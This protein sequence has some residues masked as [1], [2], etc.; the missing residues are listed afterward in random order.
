[1]F[2]LVCRQKYLK[3]PRW[4]P[5]KIVLN[6][7]KMLENINLNKLLNNFVEKHLVQN[8]GAIQDG[9]AH[10]IFLLRYLSFSFFYR[11]NWPNTF[12]KCPNTHYIVLIAC[13]RFFLNGA[14]I[15][16]GV[17]KIFEVIS[18]VLSGAKSWF[19]PF[20]YCF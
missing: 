5:P 3:W 14:I 11:P 12:C 9:L 17:L 13:K 7:L 15:Q 16:D 6:E 19:V 8:G 10:Y 1:L 2:L 20:A 4:P 18:L